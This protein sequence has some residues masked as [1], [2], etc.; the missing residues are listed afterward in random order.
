MEKTETSEEMHRLFNRTAG[1][2]DQTGVEFFV[3]VGRRLVEFAGLSAGESVLD[4]GCG[5]G[6]A[7]YPA[8]VTVG[9]GG[10]AVGIDISEEMVRFAAE[11]ADER[12]LSQVSTT[13]MNGQAPE[14]PAGRFDAVIASLSLFIW[15]KGA[16]ELKPYLPL[17]R[18]GGRFAISTPSFFPT[19]GGRWGLMPEVVDDLLMPYMRPA[20]AAEDRDFPFASVGNNWLISA[21]SVERE[22]TEAGFVEVEVLEEPLPLV[23]ESGAQ[24]VLWTR[25]TGMRR[26]W[27]KIEQLGDGGLADE[28]A[29]RLDALKDDRGVITVPVPVTYIRARAPQA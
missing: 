11:G 3:P 13:V 28:V 26:L 22:L 1:V 24:W 7:L 10:E 19:E 12:G 18:A 15:T 25:T 23:V 6:A 21:E 5:R 17:L 4:V 20:R 8:A 29:A 16:A 2:Y 9:A 27:E 14:F